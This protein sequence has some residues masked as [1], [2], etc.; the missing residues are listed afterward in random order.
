MKIDK[1]YNEYDLIKDQKLIQES[2]EFIWDGL[3]KSNPKECLKNEE[4]VIISYYNSTL[5]VKIPRW[6]INQMSKNLK[7]KLQESFGILKQKGRKGNNFIIE[8]DLI[9]I[10]VKTK[11]F[12][13]ESVHL[14]ERIAM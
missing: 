7:L 8:E 14:I 3:V 12:P 9:S 4:R 6:Y 11:F 5:K 13:M 1:S 10:M 2:I